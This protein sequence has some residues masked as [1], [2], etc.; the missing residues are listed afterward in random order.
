MFCKTCKYW[1]T[2]DFPM[3]DND[4]YGKCDMI[5]EGDPERPYEFPIAFTENCMEGCIHSFFTRSD[6]GCVL[7]EAQNDQNET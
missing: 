7:Y 3:G 6:F 1:N 4:I 5:K 2:K